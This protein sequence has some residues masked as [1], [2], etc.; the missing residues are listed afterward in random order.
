MSDPLKNVFIAL[1]NEKG[2][3]SIDVKT[4]EDVC[5]G[6]G[7][8]FDCGDAM[9][10]EKDDEG[11]WKRRAGY[12]DIIELFRGKS[13]KIEN[14]LR[15]LETSE[16]LI[17][18]IQPESVN[19]IATPTQDVSQQHPTTRRARAV[20]DR[21]RKVEQNQVKINWWD[22]P[23]E[24]ENRVL[25]ED[26][27]ETRTNGVFLSN[28]VMDNDDADSVSGTA[29]VPNISSPE[30]PNYASTDLCVVVSPT[31]TNRTDELF[32]CLDQLSNLTAD[33]TD[34]QKT[35]WESMSPKSLM[36]ELNALVSTV[37]A[38]DVVSSKLGI[39]NSTANRLRGAA[40]YIEHSVDAQ[41]DNT[42]LKIYSTPGI[43]V[44]KQSDLLST[45]RSNGGDRSVFKVSHFVYAPAKKIVKKRLRDK[46][47]VASKEQSFKLTH[48]DWNSLNSMPLHRK[49]LSLPISPDLP[50]IT[51]FRIG[52]EQSEV[53]TVGNRPVPN[54]STERRLLTDVLKSLRDCEKM[55]S[56]S[57][58]EKRIKKKKRL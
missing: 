5:Q 17:K 24:A 11:R 41:F 40:P 23:A 45:V 49:Q 29:S 12:H 57:S 28:L 7:L 42:T 46:K 16:Q 25:R 31:L 33:Y 10:I 19:E 8:N 22:T 50:A 39:Q 34:N 44:T 15:P 26:N 35:M 48:P 4:I 37:T 54:P 43:S 56:S 14:D 47:M 18:I 30:A 53:V 36:R 2:E 6:F 32:P 9:G 51:S 27:S 3:E 58:R 55:R 38:G 21:R 20:V 52:H 13:P 1:Q